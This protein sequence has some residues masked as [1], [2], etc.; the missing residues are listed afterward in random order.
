MNDIMYN[1]CGKWI[2]VE[3]IEDHVREEYFYE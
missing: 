1:T 2:V 3:K